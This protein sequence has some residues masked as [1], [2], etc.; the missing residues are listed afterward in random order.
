MNIRR[1]TLLFLCT[2]AVFACDR[3]ATTEEIGSINEPDQPTEDALTVKTQSRAYIFPHS[4]SGCAKALVDRVTDKSEVLDASVRTVLI[5]DKSSS[6]ISDAEADAIASLLARGGNLVCCE[7]TRKGID[8]LMRKVQASIR[9]AIA[10]GPFSISDEG[11]RVILNILNVI[12][13]KDGL[14]VPTFIDEGDTDGVICDILAVRGGEY[15]II[16]DLDD[17]SPIKITLTGDDDT[18][19]ESYTEKQTEDTPTTYMYGLHADALAEWLDAGSTI[20][21]GK[22]LGILSSI[23]PNEDSQDLEK[24]TNAQK[25]SYSYNAYAG[26]KFEPVTISYEIWAANDSK[27]SDYYLVHQELRA[28]NSKLVCGP[29]AEKDW[30]E[31]RVKEAFGDVAKDPRAYWAYMTRLGTQTEFSDGSVTIE[32]ISPANSIKGESTYTE[33]LTWS[34]DG[35]ITITANPSIKL[36]GNMTMSKSWTHNVM[37]LGMDFTYNGNKPKW[38]YNAGVLPK[39]TKDINKDRRHDFARPILRSDCTVGHSWIWKISNASGTYS[40]TSKTWIGIQGL[41]IDL[42]K[43][44]QNGSK[45]K[46]F[47]TEDSKVLNLNP[48]ARFEQEWIMTISPYNENTER[49]MKT[50]FPNYWLPSFSL[51]TVQENDKDAIDAQI[52]ATIAVLTENSALLKDNNVESFTLSW[53][54]LHEA[55]VYKTWSYTAP[56]KK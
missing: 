50:Y 35:A 30:N 56:K 41:Y 13:D 46:T 32:H 52:A 45:Y 6:S 15:R 26:H 44:H 47:S 48:P 54:P 36:A 43:N 12:D 18:T 49:V 11:K 37:D 28:E 19:G 42:R 25:I 24:I 55:T 27:G 33:N 16:T 10:S 7:P 22:G 5:H 9:K 53:K 8:A 38:E 31:Y 51:Y 29:T 20:S 40:F 1:L 14:L 34:I 2:L 3:Q 39:L 21:E 23:I 17:C 4:Y